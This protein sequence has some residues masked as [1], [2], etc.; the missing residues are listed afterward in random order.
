MTERP[1]ASE[2]VLGTAVLFWSYRNESHK[3]L[4]AGLVS[5]VLLPAA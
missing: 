4:R 2:P 3:T 5:V 1:D